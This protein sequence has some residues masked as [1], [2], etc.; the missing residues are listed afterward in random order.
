MNPYFD[1]HYDV[2][3]VGASL[4][5]LSSALYLAEQGLKVLC[6][7]QH[8]L[9]GG[10]ATSFVRG[11]VELEASL[12]EMM[13]IGTEAYPLSARRFLESHGANV[14]WIRLPHAYRLVTPSLNV[15]IHAGQEGDFSVPARD[16]AKACG[17]ELEEE[18]YEKLMRFFALCEK[19]RVSSDA[20]GQGDI[21]PAE[22]LKKHKSFLISSPY[23]VETIFKVFRLPKIARDILSA[24]WVYLGSPM[25]DVPFPVYGYLL[26]DYLGYGAYIPRHISYEMSLKLAEAAKRAGVQ[27]EYGQ[28]VSKILVEKGKA[29]GLRLENGIELLC[30]H[31]I[32]GAY[33][34][35]AF[36]SLIE[37]ETE[38]PK[39]AKKWVNGMEMG[40]SCFSVVML[41][42]QTPEQLGIQ[43]YAT[44]IS[45]TEF[46]CDHSYENGK[47]DGEWE[48]LT[49][50]CVNLG[51]EDASPKGTCVYSIT[52]VP[53]ADHFRGIDASEY[54]EYKR[55]H[56]EQFIESENKRL[57]IRLQDHILEIVVETPLTVSH[58]TGAYLGGIYGYRH[59]MSNHVV[60]RTLLQTKERFIKGLSFSGA[61]QISGDGMAPAIQNGI[62]SAKEI[63]SDIRR[64]KK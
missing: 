22:L 6:L 49:S 5:T 19:V 26:A 36:L 37:P 12:H 64:S 13:S 55:R 23:S 11:G 41:L 34:S 53:S 46:D 16:I 43:D 52:A 8:N 2:L 9:P 48:Y 28:R 44:F 63:L 42:D 14:D 47:T 1:D 56:A 60:T 31:I 25:G 7:E 59:T 17:P 38:V 54:E 32:C 10:V 39:K 29:K 40:V 45:Q 27:I 58:Y 20:L 3:A 61:H 4:A 30:P 50:V 21:K 57:G 18:A 24:Y 15:E 35:S 33:P 51:H 62:G